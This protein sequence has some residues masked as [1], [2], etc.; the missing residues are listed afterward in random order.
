MFSGGTSDGGQA[1]PAEGQGQCYR[2]PMNG[3]WL[4]T[5]MSH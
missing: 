2:D 1:D 5:S 3:F 4:L